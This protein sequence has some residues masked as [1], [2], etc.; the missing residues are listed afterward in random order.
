M[1][2]VC[3][4]LSHGRTVWGEV[5]LIRKISDVLYGLD[6]IAIQHDADKINEVG[7]RIFCDC[8]EGIEWW[9]LR[10][11]CDELNRTL[12]DRKETTGT[13]L[14]ITAST[15]W[16]KPPINMMSYSEPTTLET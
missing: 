3:D 6:E 4:V 5:S 2:E 10:P 14:T 15:M 8:R 16:M 9:N 1:S 13:R 7:K 11:A 12:P